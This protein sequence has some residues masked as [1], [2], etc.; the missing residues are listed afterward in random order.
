[1]NDVGIFRD[2]EPGWDLHWIQDGIEIQSNIAYLSNGNWVLLRQRTG[3][4]TPIINPYAY[5]NLIKEICIKLHFKP[6][7]Y[8]WVWARESSELVVARELSIKFPRYSDVLKRIG[9]IY[10]ENYQWELKIVEKIPLNI[11]ATKTLYENFG[12]SDL[13]LREKSW[14][15]NK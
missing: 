15:Y 5:S 8:R 11:E 6:Y 12:I 1:M 9:N 13:F 3:S 10:R 7:S 14:Q 2:R 4:L